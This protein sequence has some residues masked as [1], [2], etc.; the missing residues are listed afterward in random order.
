MHK[1]AQKELH[2]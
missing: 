1:A 2:K